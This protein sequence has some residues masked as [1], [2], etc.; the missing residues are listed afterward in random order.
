LTNT[1]ESKIASA[2]TD[3]FGEGY[4]VQVF[5]GGQ[6]KKGSGGKR[7]GSIR[8]DEGKAADVY[9]V[10]PDGKRVTDPEVLDNLK[11]YW[12]QNKLG[13]IGTY[14]NGGGIHLDEWTEDQLL[15][16]MGTSWSY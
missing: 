13:S 14:M 16:G 7:T 11:N 8:H 9:I 15:A 6:P 4:T 2:V 5:S 12:R 10:D 1:L 3:V